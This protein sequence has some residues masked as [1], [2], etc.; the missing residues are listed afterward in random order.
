MFQIRS[1]IFS[2][3]NYMNTECLYFLV[4][5]CDKYR[6]IQSYTVEYYYTILYILMIVEISCVHSR[7][8]ITFSSILVYSQVYFFKFHNFTCPM[9][10]FF[11]Y[12]CVFSGTLFW[13]LIIFSCL[14][15]YLME[16]ICQIVFFAVKPAAMI[17]SFFMI[18]TN[19]ILIYLWDVRTSLWKSLVF[20]W[21]ILVI[22]FFS[23][24]IYFVVSL[25][26]KHK[27]IIIQFNL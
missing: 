25:T 6:K 19:V 17:F 15:V 11:L 10:S 20:K 14:I 26:I 16:Y 18:L 9:E 3:N 13:N 23:L 24:N 4:H 7:I 12:I 21:S 22:Q 5:V 1:C 27:I 2:H 8:G